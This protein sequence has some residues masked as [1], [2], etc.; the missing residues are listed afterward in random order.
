[1]GQQAD[2][3]VSGLVCSLCGQ[4]IDWSEPGHPRTCVQCGGETE[5]DDSDEAA[6]RN[7]WELVEDE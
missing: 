3:L 4:M 5:I 2:D 7:G 6:L 1:M